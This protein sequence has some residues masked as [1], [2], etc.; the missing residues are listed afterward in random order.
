MKKFT[1]LLVAVC[2]PVLALAN[3]NGGL[4]IDTGKLL[5]FLVGIPLVF[6]INLVLAIRNVKRKNG[7]VTVINGILS[8]PLVI[9]AVYAFNYTSGVATFLVLFAILHLYLIKKSIPS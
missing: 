1:S 6:I 7:A 2:L 5:L 8:L 4:H 9:G 3:M